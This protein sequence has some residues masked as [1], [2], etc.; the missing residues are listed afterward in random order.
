[1]P[2]TVLTS[3]GAP[4]LDWRRVVW[5]SR[6]DDCELRKSEG[7]GLPRT[8]VW[9]DRAY[10]GAENRTTSAYATSRYIHRRCMSG[11]SSARAKYV[12]AWFVFAMDAWAALRWVL[13]LLLLVALIA[14]SAIGLPFWAGVTLFVLFMAVTATSAIFR[15][16]RAFRK[17]A[18][19]DSS[20]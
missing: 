12:R 3:R 4:L 13:A 17:A 10:E 6:S 18:R 15:T 8:G 2:R 19:G 14:L 11:G 9:S 7:P 16:V 1:V 5:L 20:P